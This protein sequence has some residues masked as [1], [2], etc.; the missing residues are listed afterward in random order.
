[1]A[2]SK[3]GLYNR[4]LRHLGQRHLA[5]LADNVESRRIMDGVWEDAPDYCLEHGFWSFA[6]RTKEI[7][8]DGDIVP[9][10]GPRYGF[11]LPDDCLRTYELSNDQNFIPQSVLFSNE[12]RII[13][14]DSTPIFLSYVSN[15]AGY[16]RDLSLW[17]QTFA[18]YVALRMAVLACTSLTQAESKLDILIKLEKRALDSALAKDAMGKP[19]GFLP[20]GTWVRSRGGWGR[21]SDILTVEESR[22]N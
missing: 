17:P 2:I 21:W 13:Y 15:D 9:D 14:A 22:G 11:Q 10:F 16:G 20:T 7:D 8:A 12:R 5:T 19:P 4:A 6:I 18:E 1:M 3:L